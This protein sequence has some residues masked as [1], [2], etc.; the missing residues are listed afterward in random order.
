MVLKKFRCP[1]WKREIMLNYEESNKECH[2]TDNPALQYSGGEA[3]AT[4]S[5]IDH[6][7]FTNFKR[8]VAWKWNT[9]YWS[10]QMEECRYQA[11]K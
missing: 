8:F 4:N 6:T 9:N 2:D 1:S 3:G 5:E 7:N 10:K 11:N